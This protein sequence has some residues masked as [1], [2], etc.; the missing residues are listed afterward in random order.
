MRL[1]DSV[2]FSLL[3][4]GGATLWASSGGARSRN[5][6]NDP[7]LMSRT[8]VVSG[9]DVYTHRETVRTTIKT[10]FGDI[11]GLEKPPFT[12]GRRANSGYLQFK[13]DE[14]KQ[15]FLKTLKGPTQ[16]GSLT[17]YVNREKTQEDQHKDTSV[18]KLKKAMLVQEGKVDGLKDRIDVLRGSGVVLADNTKVGAWNRLKGE[19]QIKVASIDKMILGF[20]GAEVLETWTAEMRPKEREE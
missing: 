19:F 3:W 7:T 20:S 5:Y 1:L 4:N 12:Y 15:S 14:E 13:S 16:H 6:E 11:P 10:I 9:F 17:I 2:S 18:G 8:A